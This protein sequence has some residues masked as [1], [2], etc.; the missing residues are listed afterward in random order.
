MGALTSGY[1]KR[2]IIE[3]AFSWPGRSAPVLGRSTEPNADGAENIPAHFRVVNCCA[4]GR[5]H[6]GNWGTASPLQN[7]ATVLPLPFIRGEGRGEGLLLRVWVHLKAWSWR[8]PHTF[9]TGVAGDSSSNLRSRFWQNVVN[10][11]LR[12]ASSGGSA[13]RGTFRISTNLPGFAAIKKTRSPK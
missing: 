5:A 12:R 6:S 11:G 7:Q 2:G 13:G 8:V 9:V 4:R 10:H 1:F 3:T